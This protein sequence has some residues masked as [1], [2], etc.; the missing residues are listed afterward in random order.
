MKIMYTRSPGKIIFSFEFLVPTE[1]ALQP[2]FCERDAF[3]A[4]DRVVSRVASR[5]TK[6]VNNL[7][8]DDPK[9]FLFNCHY[10]SWTDWFQSWGNS[11]KL[12]H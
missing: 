2:Q 6:S 7:P 8:K 12:H 10:Y 4:N 1:S 5:R 11:R 9:S 3:L